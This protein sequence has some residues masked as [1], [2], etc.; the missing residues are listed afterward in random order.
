MTD[1]VSRSLRSMERQRND[2][3]QTRDPG[4]GGQGGRG[5]HGSRLKAG[6]REARDTKTLASQAIPTI[7]CINISHVPQPLGQPGPI[8]Y[9]QGPSS[10]RHP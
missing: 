3:L 1:I 2:A 4:V 10:D 7:S 5:Q 9:P 8:W 6:T